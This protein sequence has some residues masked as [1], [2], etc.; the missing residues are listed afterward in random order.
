M[1][2]PNIYW[3]RKA[4]QYAREHPSVWQVGP[5][6]LNK[7]GWAA[8]EV[9]FAVSLPGRFNKAGVT[10]RGVRRIEPVRFVFPPSFPFGRPFIEL[11]DDFDRT[12]P[13]INPNAKKVLPCVYAGSLADLLQQPKWFDHILDQT[14]D[15]LNKAASDDLMN[16]SQ[17]WEPTRLDRVDG[18]VWYSDESIKALIKKEDVTASAFAMWRNDCVLA[19]ALAPTAKWKETDRTLVFGFAPRGDGNVV[20]EMPSAVETF[21]DLHDFALKCGITAM[22]PVIDESIGDLAANRKPGFLVLLALRRP[23]HLIGSTSDI[24]ILNYIVKTAPNNK[25][26]KISMKAPVKQIAHANVCTPELLAKCSGVKLGGALSIVQIGCGSLGS[27][28]ALHIARTGMARFTLVDPGSFLPHNNARHALTNDHGVLS[29]PKAELLARSMLAMGIPATPVSGNILAEP[30]LLAS[31]R[32]VIDATASVAVRNFLAITPFSGRLANASLYGEGR[33]G[34]LAIEGDARMPRIDD[35]ICSMFST[36]LRDDRLRDRLCTEQNQSVQLGQGCDS[37]TVQC[38]DSRISIVAAGM[39]SCLESMFSSRLPQKGS[40][41]VGHVGA[42]GMSINW[43]CITEGTPTILPAQ[44]DTEWEVRI[45][46]SVVSEME[47]RAVSASPVETGGALIGHISTTLKCL[48]ITDILPPPPDSIMTETLFVLGVKGL[49]ATVR[50]IQARTNSE[51]TYIGTWHS[52]PHGG[53]ASGTDSKT[54]V[55]LLVLRDY[56]PTVCLIWTPN[57]IVRV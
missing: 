35:L 39:A 49:R 50:A 33:T 52:H 8:I 28:I 12:F 4:Y 14:A 30:G 19:G 51:L 1:E 22:K 3:L 7:D 43:T 17:G 47:K 13:H 56:E 5:I 21:S 46:H 41:R 10:D 25:N 9:H 45:L 53:A 29:G 23:A 2:L 40:L 48:T 36:A 15:W 24:E 54:K 42:D 37:I 38:P 32:L 55:R 18:C 16:L 6:E 44:S 26:G 11:R 27:K 57:G 34:V 20:H 31:G